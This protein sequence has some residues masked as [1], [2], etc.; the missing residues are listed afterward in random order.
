MQS[1]ASAWMVITAKIG[2]RGNGGT[3]KPLF[4]FNSKCS[5]CFPFLLNTEGVSV[6]CK[7]EM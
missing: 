2:Q 5:F 1:G 6:K 4:Q 7:C 3:H